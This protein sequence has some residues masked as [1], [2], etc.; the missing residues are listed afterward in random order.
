MKQKVFLAKTSHC[1]C[2]LREIDALRH[3]Q[4]FNPL[5]YNI[6]TLMIFH[7][8]SLKNEKL[9]KEK[10]PVITLII[11]PLAILLNNTLAA[12]FLP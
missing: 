4:S 9:K 3:L 6:V 5:R 11:H 8:H 7:S 10:I 1:T 12:L 2:L